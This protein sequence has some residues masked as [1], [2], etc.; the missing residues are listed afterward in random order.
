M[1]LRWDPFLLAAH[2]LSPVPS[3]S[4]DSHAQNVYH[5][6]PAP[7]PPIPR[8]HPTYHLGTEH[9]IRMRVVR[10]QSGIPSAADKRNPHLL[11]TRRHSS[12]PRSL[13]RSQQ[14]RRLPLRC[15]DSDGFDPPPRGRARNGTVITPQSC[16][17]EW[18]CFRREDVWGWA[19]PAVG[20]GGC[21][22]GAC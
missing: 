1:T 7:Q 4:A 14:C 13:A 6:R 5:G 10:R 17:W 18:G 19:G 16:R 21:V 9:P 15:R 12:G 3:P 2:H 20:S 11:S 22:G 8:Y